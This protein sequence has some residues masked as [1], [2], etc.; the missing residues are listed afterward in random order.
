[1]STTR[2]DAIGTTALFVAALR[3]QE[4]LRVDRLIDDQYAARFL[5]AAGASGVSAPGDVTKF[6][7]LMADQVALRTRFLDDALLAAAAGGCRQVVLVAAGMD[8]RAFRLPWPAGV[9]LF[10]LDQPDVLRFKDEVLAGTEPRCS[11]R[12]IGVDLRDDWA[13]PLRAA[14]FRVDRPTAWLTEGLL[15][16]LTT[17]AATGLLDTIGSLSG[18]GSMIAFDHLQMCDALRQALVAADPGLVDLWLGGPDD[19][20]AWLRLNHWRPRADEMAE[21]GRRHG[22]VVPPA[23]DPAAGGAHSWLV[24]ATR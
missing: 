2:L 4:T 10:E 18:T 9:E 22:R 1:M 13:K 5:A 24:T 6:V 21:L 19:P 3:A 20:E 23:Y 12:P 11:R 16:A 17:Q 15:Y 14:G 8:S 7:G